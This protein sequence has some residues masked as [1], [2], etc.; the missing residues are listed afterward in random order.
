[1]ENHGDEK[2]NNIQWSDESVIYS[3]LF[4]NKVVY[5]SVIFLSILTWDTGSRFK[6][7]RK[8]TFFFGAGKYTPRD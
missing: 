1:M 3:H 6:N 8:N 4:S 7:F 5:Y 2:E